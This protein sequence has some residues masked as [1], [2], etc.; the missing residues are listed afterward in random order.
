MDGLPV[1]GIE[2]FKL[3]EF[4]VAIVFTCK[5]MVG[6]VTDVAACFRRHL[7]PMNKESNWFQREHFAWHCL[8]DTV[9][10][11]SMFCCAVTYAIQLC[12][13]AQV[14]EGCLVILVHFDVG[15]VRCECEVSA[16]H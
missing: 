16:I 6:P 5:V 4:T 7:F 9:H 11:Y 15:V 8:F 1:D 12:F 13:P 14:T 2:L 10:S 3:Q